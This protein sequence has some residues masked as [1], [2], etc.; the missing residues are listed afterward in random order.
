M[1]QQ[2]TFSLPP[3]LVA[4]SKFENHLPSYV[5]GQRSRVTCLLLR[6]KLRGDNSCL[7][8]FFFLED[9]YYFHHGDQKKVLLYISIVE[10]KAFSSLSELKGLIRFS[11][12]VRSW[13]QDT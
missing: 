9:N 7:F 3:L 1:Q 13:L 6:L 12:N 5:E 8:L 11:F 4:V 2:H 10:L